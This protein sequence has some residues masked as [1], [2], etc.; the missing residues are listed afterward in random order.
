MLFRML[1]SLV[2]LISFLWSHMHGLLAYLEIWA[3]DS[4]VPLCAFNSCTIKEQ[5]SVASFIQTLGP[6]KGLC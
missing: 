2:D 5:V 6:L 3:S 1:S 4:L